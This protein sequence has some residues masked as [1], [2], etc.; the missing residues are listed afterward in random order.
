MCKEDSQMPWKNK[1]HGLS[2]AIRVTK[3]E[4]SKVRN[5]HI[6]GDREPVLG[7][8]FLSDTKPVTS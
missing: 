2:I 6:F 3:H 5:H 7:A 8:K 4:G 1:G